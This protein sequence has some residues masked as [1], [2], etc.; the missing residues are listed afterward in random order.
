MSGVSLHSVLVAATM[1]PV[2]ILR[3]VPHHRAAKLVLAGS[4][5]TLRA[6]PHMH[7]VPDDAVPALHPA[8]DAAAVGGWAQATSPRAAA[9]K[10]RALAGGPSL[11]VRWAVASA[12]RCPPDVLEDLAR[13]GVHLPGTADSAKHAAA[14]RFMEPYRGLLWLWR[15]HD[16]LAHLHRDS[17]LRDAFVAPVTMLVRVAA[18]ANPARSG[19]AMQ[20][21]PQRLRAP[22]DRER[23]LS[24]ALGRAAGLC[25]IGRSVAAA[26]PH[27]PRGAL[28]ALHS[29]PDPFVAAVTAR[30]PSAGAVA[31]RAAS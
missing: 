5:A 4:D 20:V 13:W 30:N 7:D 15:H 14:E 23:F 19:S 9:A 21:E 25:H 16:L 24:Y 10:L 3:A 6:A 2:D 22:P 11:R 28:E 12:R 18:A 17:T 26:H 31:A 8:P 27:T 1:M 29:D